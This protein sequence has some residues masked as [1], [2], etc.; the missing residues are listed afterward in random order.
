[1]SL[2]FIQGLIFSSWMTERKPQK[3]EKPAGCIQRKLQWAVKAARPSEGFTELQKLWM[4]ARPRRRGTTA[5][6]LDTGGR[7]L[8]GHVWEVLMVTFNINVA[9]KWKELQ[10]AARLV[11][12]ELQRRSCLTV[13]PF[14]NKLWKY[15]INKLYSLSVKMKV[16]A[17]L[18]LWGTLGGSAQ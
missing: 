7:I 15:Q 12:K 3:Q 1:M 18:R 9:W 11:L 17:L 4:A 6:S 16:E 10:S 5:W 13:L 2:S 14:L 8:S